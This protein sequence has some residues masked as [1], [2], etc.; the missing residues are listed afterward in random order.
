MS[1]AVRLGATRVEQPLRP[2]PVEEPSESQGASRAAGNTESPGRTE[3]A[4]P[5]SAPGAA[6]PITATDAREESRLVATAR[7]AL[8]SGAPPQ[9]LALLEQA[10]VRFPAGILLQERDALM[11][12]ALVRAGQRAAAAERGRAFAQAYPG[13]PYTARIQSILAAP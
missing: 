9:A 3:T 11:I 1:P 10:R 2:T 6:T 4:R 7:E 8:R 12:E 13:S 5:A